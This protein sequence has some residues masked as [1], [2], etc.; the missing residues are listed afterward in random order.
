MKTLKL[1][2]VRNIPFIDCKA[3]G[4]HFQKSGKTYFIEMPFIAISF[5]ITNNPLSA[6]NRFFS[7]K[8][9]YSRLDSNI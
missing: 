9:G 2:A 4:F 6:I 5:R 3:P 7:I 8:E 1:S